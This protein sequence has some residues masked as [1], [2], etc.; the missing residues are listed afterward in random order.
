MDFSFTEE[1][2]LLRNT[3]QNLLSDKYDFETRRKVAKSAEGWRP[4]IWSQCAKLGLIAATFSEEQ[5]GIGGSAIE[6]MNVMEELG[7]H[8]VIE[9]YL[10]TVVIAG[11]LRRESVSAAQQEAHIPGIS[12]GETVWAF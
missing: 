2:T 10:E 8:L 12:G 4:E 7:R 1:Q 9:P 11:G 3:V 6:T 5:G